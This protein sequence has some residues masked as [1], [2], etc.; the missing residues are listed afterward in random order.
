MT[1][2]LH[3]YTGTAITVVGDKILMLVWGG[4]IQ[5]MEGEGDDRFPLNVPLPEEDGK[6]TQ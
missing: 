4:F 3:A 2:L 1:F 6:I 5:E